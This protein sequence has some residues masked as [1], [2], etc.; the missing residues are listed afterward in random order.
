MIAGVSRRAGLLALVAYGALLAATAPS[1]PDD[2]DGVGFV[3][4]VRDFDL[5]RFHPHP[6]GYPVYVAL[7]RLAALGAR[8]PMRACVLIAALSGVIT[9]GLAWD[10]V[11]RT[12][13]EPGAW[14]VACLLGVVPLTWRACSGVGSE[15]PALACAAACAWGLI[16]AR[17][18]E[19]P[20]RGWSVAALA[21][22]AGLGLG[23][24]LSWAPLYLAALAC[25]PRGARARTWGVTVAVCAAWA[26]PLVALVGPARLADLTLTHFAGHAARWGGS[27]ATE[28]GAVRLSWLARDVLVDG[29][30]AGGD[31][32]GLAT[33][34]LLGM[35]G[36][37]A[38]L[39]WRRAGWRGWAFAVAVVA[40]YLLWIAL[41]QNLRDQPRHALPL[42]ALLAAAL[43]LPASRSRSALAVVGALALLVSL[44]TAL[45]AQ[46]R[47][48][49]PPP[50]QQLVEL[51]R[52]QVAP[53]RLAVFGVSSVRFF[54]LTELA[55][56]AFAAGSLG[57][58]QVRLARLDTLP[59]R[60]WVT[61]ELEGLT[62]SAWPLE[63]VATL[64]RPPR[65]D[66]RLPCL[67]VYAW[68]LPFLP[69]R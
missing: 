59:A 32:L 58:V 27:V 43:A 17:A 33:S 63:H 4:S 28:P 36:V 41:G 57:D 6:P 13:G 66:R 10:V 52:A 24:R 40:P 30:G 20:R 18:R 37:Q 8:D 45:D 26:A 67:E 7:L 14:A 51:A 23:V 50:G 1:W 54:E 53:A 22:G 12:M 21:L 65:L 47:R 62:G 15:A 35:A 2:W 25:A 46:A 64:C 11:R 19:A 49:I 34:A 55:D 68:K 5:A 39:A 44:R 16:S 29:L 9:V 38:L 31:A 3:E 56:R 69:A 61:G 60:V 48:T 42:V